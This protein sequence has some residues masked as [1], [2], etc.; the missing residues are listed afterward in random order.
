M[1]FQCELEQQPSQPTLCVKAQVPVTELPMALGKAFGQIMGLLESRGEQPAGM[2]YVAYKN[3]DMA[4]LDVE[5]GFPVAKPLEGKGEVE[6]GALPGGTWAATLHVGPYDQVGPAWDALQQFIAASG[7]KARGVGYEF[8]F[9]PPET[10][11]EKIRTRI[12]F[13]LEN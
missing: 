5:I 11:P 9:D 2:P 7:R 13:P 12:M 8:Y 6:P 10:P 3:L 1:A 4:N